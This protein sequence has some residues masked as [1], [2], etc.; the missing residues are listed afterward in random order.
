MRF[1]YEFTHA[2]V[3]MFIDSD[4][5]LCLTKHFSDEDSCAEC[6]VQATFKF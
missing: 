3:R 2:S 1:Y 5:P 6:A 4:N